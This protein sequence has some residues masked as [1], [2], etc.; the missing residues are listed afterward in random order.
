DGATVAPDDA[1]GLA[2]PPFAAV[3]HVAVRC[4]NAH[5]A[6]EGEG[7]ARSGDP[8]ESAL[9]VTAA[10]ASVDVLAAQ[11]ER[12][13]TRIALAHFDSRRKRMS[14]VAS[15]RD[16]RCVHAKV[17]PLELLDR[18]TRVLDAEGRERALDEQ[19]R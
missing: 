13:R 18:C 3:L 9:L 8:S 14:T 17:A 10:G 16:G 19:E 11:D 5:L 1:A 15:E 12:D 7:Y 2:G 6:A 4:S